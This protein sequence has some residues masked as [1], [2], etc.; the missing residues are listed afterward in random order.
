MSD[1]KE[2]YKI[3]IVEDNESLR[4][5]L[6]EALVREKY[7]VESAANGTIAL[8]KM[9]VNEFQLVIS[10]FKMPGIDGITL[11]H[12]V[13]E[14]YLNTEF[15]LI[16]AYATVEIAV[17]SLKKGIKDFITKPFPIAE[18]RQKVNT[19]FL[20][21]K[22]EARVHQSSLKTKSLIGKSSQIKKIKAIIDKVAKVN[23]PVL[24]TGESG[25]GKELVARSIHEKSDFSKGNFISINCGAL[26]SSLLESELFGHEKGSFTGAVNSHAGKF[27]QAEGGTLFLDEIG[28]MDLN[29]Q[30]KLLRV[31]QEKQ[32]QRVGGEKF[33]APNFRLLAATNRN[34]KAESEKGNFRSDLYYRLNVVPIEMPALRDRPQDIPF[35]I[36]DII[37]EKCHKLNRSIP[38]IEKHLLEKITNYSWPGNVR[39]LEN[40][41][42]RSLIFLDG[43]ILSDDFLALGENP[44]KLDIP[45]SDDLF[46]TLENIEREMIINALRKNNGIK[47]KTARKLNIKPSTLYYRMEKLNILEEDY[48]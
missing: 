37:E 22:K 15:I 35:L 48:L 42:E 13:K 6:V 12:R 11:F 2:T 29:L 14:K 4:S 32:F 28:E 34:L 46:E 27:E 31:L 21:W 9:K 41:L 43:E 7:F 24:I 8:E 23:T 39:E 40:F 5:G 10:D 19:I 3:L 47:Q 25:T 33:I 38:A 18:F 44:V 26:S 1:L 17:D 16:T 20:E 30:V 45:E 36:D